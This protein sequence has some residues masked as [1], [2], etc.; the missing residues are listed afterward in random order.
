M[1]DNQETKPSQEHTA[2][3]KPSI[4]PGTY[5]QLPGSNSAAK[6]TWPDLVGLMAE[7]AERKIK[8]DFPRAQI[9]VVQPDCFVTMDFKQDRVRLYVDSSGKVA[10]IPKIG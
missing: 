6:T 5:G 1:A 9:Q 2:Q 8:E 7:E 4:L 10:R 3:S